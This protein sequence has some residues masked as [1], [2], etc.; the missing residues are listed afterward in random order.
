MKSFLVIGV[1]R[2][3][4]AVAKKLSDLGHEVLAMDKVEHNI[5][6]VSEV[7]THAIIA[8]ATDVKILRTL[9]G[10]NYD[11]AIVAVGEDVGDSV[12]IALALK[13]LGVKQI[14]SK[15]RDEQH[16]KILQKI[17]VDQVIIPEHEAGARLAVNVA[18]LN[19][20]DT[21]ELSDTYGVS[22]LIAPLKW[23]GKRIG[24]IDIRRKYGCV[25]AAVKK[26]STGEEEEVIIAP[27]ADYVF[28]HADL[29]VLIGENEQINLL[30]HL[31]A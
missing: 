29:L 18:E 7:V 21:L 17:G 27:K 23:E 5:Q 1:G 15:A 4:G 31:K 26:A 11:C 19:L 22:E 13:E 25:V 20:I 30:S 8:D 12:L 14:I 6:N 10:Q 24:E 2:F 3:G 9:G 16:K 28:E